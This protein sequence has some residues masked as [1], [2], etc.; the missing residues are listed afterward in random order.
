MSVFKK[1]RAR[2]KGCRYIAIT[3]NAVEIAPSIVDLCQLLGVSIE[4]SEMR[5]VGDTYIVQLDDVSMEFCRD[6]RKMSGLFLDRLHKADKMPF[7]LAVV[8]LVM[9][10]IVMVRG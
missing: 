3:R 1:L 9:L 10:F 5:R 7:Y 2:R 4:E 6:K 8:Q